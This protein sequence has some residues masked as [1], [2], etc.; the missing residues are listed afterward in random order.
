LA[1]FKEK[2]GIIG[3]MVAIFRSLWRLSDSQKPN[4]VGVKAE[5]EA[6]QT[7]RA[8]KSFD[9]REGSWTAA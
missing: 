5:T 9:F 8:S 4:F 7:P 3:I 1:G 2:Q 6:P